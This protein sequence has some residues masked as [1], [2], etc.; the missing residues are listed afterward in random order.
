MKQLCIIP[1]YVCN[2]SCSWCIQK[3]RKHIKS[4]LDLHDLKIII[5]NIDI[6]NIVI[7]GGEVSIL[8]NEYL[9]EFI[10]LMESKCKPISISTNLFVVK[11][12]LTRHNLNVSWDFDRQNTKNIINN[13]LSLE[14]CS[15]VTTVTPYLLSLDIEYIARFYSIFNN[16]SSVSFNFFNTSKI[17]KN[18]DVE[19][20]VEFLEKIK[21]HIK[22]PISQFF[23]NEICEK[24][25]IAPSKDG[26][27]EVDTTNSYYENYGCGGCDMQQYCTLHTP[28]ESPDKCKYKDFIKK[29]KYG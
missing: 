4:K 19:I 1:S 6:D 5:D 11:D 29:I 15:L 12:R 10:A 3:T 8:P 13:I 17:A 9:N 18:N 26:S 24:I 21:E 25:T 7:L 16:V 28:V 2:F 27:I 14:K 23:V 20:Y 22:L